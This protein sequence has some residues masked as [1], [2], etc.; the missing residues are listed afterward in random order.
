MTSRR[1]VRRNVAGAITV[2]LTLVACGTSHSSGGASSILDVASSAVVTTWDPIQSFS[3]EVAYVANLY[4]PLLYAQPANADGSTSFKPG[5][6]TSWTHSDDGKTWTFKIRSGVTFHDGEA[7]TAAS[8]AASLQA[9]AKNGGASF[10]W[11][12]L[13]GITTP[14]TST[15]VIAMK[16]PQPVDLIASS[17]YGAYIVAPNALA[18]VAKDAK[19]F[20][21]G[22]D[23]GTGP[24]TLSSYTAGKQVVLKKYP[25]YWGGWS[26]SHYGTIVVSITSEAI[27]QQQML[28]GGQAQL[29]DSVPLVNLADLAKTFNVDSA[30]SAFSYVGFFNTLRP[31]LDNAMV[32]QA[33]SYAI[34]YADIV[35]VGASGQGTQD[36]A[37]VPAGIFPYS[38]DV[39]EYQQDLAKAADLLTQAGHPGGKFS[40]N[41]TYAAENQGEARFAPLIK[42]AFAKIG[43]TVNLKAI[44]FDQQWA[45]AKGTPASAQDMFLLLYWPTYADAG[46]D[47]LHTLFHSSD[48]PF[49]N[50]SY[51]KD[52]TYDGLIDKAAGLTQTDRAQSLAI[53]VQAQKRL[54]DQ[55]PGVFFYDQK[56]V[57][58][59]AKTVQGLE[60]NVNYP[61]V[62]FYYPLHHG[63]A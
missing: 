44:L 48:K 21:A 49:F 20:D 39:P 3:T 61:F 27:V 7:L 13:A 31:P 30:P 23:A 42:D 53:Y 29:A 56:A 11:S 28:Q 55:A 51:W 46:N 58:V 10:I 35:T 54:V 62:T 41:L 63:A 45:Q 12:D 9:S 36:R 52:S 32:R 57:V 4:E 60:N 47:N 18:A 25:K 2:A 8:V 34:P 5:L 50:L 22:I 40:L 33:L 43:V 26:G 24:Y 16:D 38:A 1:S 15:V 14:D 17:E 19:Y 6:A 37:S 59:T